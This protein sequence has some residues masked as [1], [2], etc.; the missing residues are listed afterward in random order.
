MMRNLLLLLLLVLTSS[1]C[2]GQSFTLSETQWTPIFNEKDFAG[3]ETYLTRPHPSIVVEGWPKN[4]KGEYTKPLGINNDPKN[5]FTVVQADGIP[6]IRISGEVFGCLA[7]LQEFENYHLKFEFKWGQLKWPPRQNDVRDGGLLYHSYGPHGPGGR[8]WMESQEC[9]IQEGDC[10][11]YWA[12]G[13]TRV[14]IVSSNGRYDPKGQ[15]MAYGY[16]TPGGPR[17][18]KSRNN[19]R[20]LGE[21]NTIEVI[22]YRDKAIHKVNGETVLILTNSRTKKAEKETAVVKGKIQL[23][24]EGA[25]M[26][27]RNIQIKKI[28]KLPE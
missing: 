6:A 3:W 19:E 26:Y 22:C 13:D 14:D 28:N 17:C 21:W 12:V 9:Q 2:L 24:S 8:T 11:D 16:G 20:P 27:I 1:S 4:E 23:Q 25:E 15:T 5:V 10:G 7:T 18:L